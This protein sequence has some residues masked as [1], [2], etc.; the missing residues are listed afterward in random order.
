MMMM[1][2]THAAAFLLVAL[3]GCSTVEKNPSG[4]AP[5]GPA[6]PDPVE[7]AV[8]SPFNDLN[9]VRSKVPDALLSAR[10]A[11]YALPQVPGCDTLKAEVEALNAALGADLDTP[12]TAANPGLVE[13]GS[14]ELGDAA[15]GALRGAAE[16]LVPFRGWV[17]K[18]T[19]AERN[20]RE[21]AA[22]IA[23]GTVRRAFLK[24]VG[25]AHECPAPAAPSRKPQVS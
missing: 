1:K 14:S 15:G 20:S 13:R 2:N 4:P 23:A 6:K 21:F 25:L 12:A 24:G 7:Q 19:G 3:A 11:P 8:L 10:A 22:A 9:L 18:L 5:A 17:R 16:G